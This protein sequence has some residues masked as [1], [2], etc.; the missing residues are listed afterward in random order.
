MSSGYGP[1]YQTER[2]LH[3]LL[4]LA[5]LCL[6]CKT[7]DWY[8]FTWHHHTW[9]S[10]DS[11][12]VFSFK[13]LVLSFQFKFSVFGV[14][15][16]ALAC[17]TIGWYIKVICDQLHTVSK[18]KCGVSF[19][20]HHSSFPIFLPSL[21]SFLLPRP[22]L[23][24]SPS[25]HYLLILLFPPSLPSL[26]P[27]L[28]PPPSPSLSSSLPPSL[29]PSLSSSLP[30]STPFH[31]SFSS[32]PPSCHFIPPLFSLPI[33]LFLFLFASS[34]P[35]S[36]TPLSMFSSGVTCP[37]SEQG[38]RIHPTVAKGRLHPRGERIATLVHVVFS[39]YTISIKYTVQITSEVLSVLSRSSCCYSLSSPFGLTL[40]TCLSF[41]FTLRLAPL[42]VL[43]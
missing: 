4:W 26:P 1:Y 30:P 7:S 43:W 22:P 31:L 8:V 23:P 37:H 13:F 10:S 6:F 21:L 34:L 33:L 28:P 11:I 5:L 35:L 20:L 29:L 15:I 18:W 38:Y 9:P 19:P 2:S 25:L 17:S 36:L 40:P 39:A 42:T 24:P 27:S 41:A 16:E 12:S 14:I 32:L 3:C